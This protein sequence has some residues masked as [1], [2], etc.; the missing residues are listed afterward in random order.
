ML[1]LE[2]PGRLDVAR[3]VGDTRPLAL[4]GA[5]RT[6]PRGSKLEKW[7]HPG[8]HTAVVAQALEKSG[9]P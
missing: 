3:G 1:A 9:E 8:I 2:L 5:T 7:T 4:A 6:S